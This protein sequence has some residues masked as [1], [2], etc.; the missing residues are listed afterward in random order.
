MPQQP[1]FKDCVWES[2]KDPQNTFRTMIWLCIF[3]GIVANH[4]VGPQLERFLDLFLLCDPRA[5]TTQP[6]FLMDPRLSLGDEP[7]NGLIRGSHVTRHESPLSVG[8]C[9]EAMGDTLGSEARSTTSQY[10]DGEHESRGG[11]PPIPEGEE[12]PPSPNATESEGATEV[13]QKAAEIK[14]LPSPVKSGRMSGGASWFAHSD[15]HALALSQVTDSYSSLGPK[16]QLLDRRL[17]QTLITVVRGPSLQLLLA[18]K[19]DAQ[20]YTYWIIALWKHAELGGSNRRTAA[21]AAMQAVKFQGDA[22]QWKMQVMAASREITRDIR[23]RG[24]HRALHD[25]VHDDILPGKI[26]ASTVH[27]GQR[28][29]L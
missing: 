15:V 9:S 5:A 29:Q 25:G 11:L 12:P 24:D 19:G 14:R 18:L 8:D 26:S 23:L 13:A 22:G 7:P 21:M 20:R 1:K 2:A 27:E 28:Y 4:N 17:F 6:S 10:D 3:S 16:A